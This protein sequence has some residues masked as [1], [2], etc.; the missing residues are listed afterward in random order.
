MLYLRLMALRAIHLSSADA[1][2]E[3]NFGLDE[4]YHLELPVQ[5]SVQPSTRRPGLNAVKGP[6]RSIRIP[7]SLSSPIEDISIVSSSISLYNSLLSVTSA[8]RRSL[9]SFTGHADYHTVLATPLSLSALCPLQTRSEI[10]FIL[11]YVAKEP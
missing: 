7:V 9:D 6:D 10:S 3:G 11:R 5:A 8:F 4:H 2:V 1:V